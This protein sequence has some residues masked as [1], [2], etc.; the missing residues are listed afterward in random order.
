MKEKSARLTEI[1]FESGQLVGRILCPIQ[2]GPGQY[3]LAQPA[4]RITFALPATLFSAGQ[5]SDGF[6]AAPPLPAGWRPGDDLLVK[7]PLGNGF[8]LPDGIHRLGLLA[9]D[10]TISRL[11]PL[12][13]PAFK[14]GSAVTLVCDIAH[15]GLPLTDIP[16]ELEI[17]PFE[18]LP[19]LLTWADFLALD[20]AITDLPHLR[21]R[22]GLKPGERLPCQAQILVHTA[23]PCAGAAECGICAVRTKHRWKLACKD[24]PVFNLNDLEW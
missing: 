8:N 14:S 10:A 22:L 6:I 20:L 11:L 17:A 4:G 19:S 1:W 12:V 23:M 13:S 21:S 7:G 2:P 15:S 16:S 9:M 5:T 3:I 18:S 24:G